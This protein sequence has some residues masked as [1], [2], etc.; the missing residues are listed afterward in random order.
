MVTLRHAIKISALRDRVFSALADTDE[1]AAWHIG[2]VDGDIAVGSTFRPNPKPGVVF[3]WRTEEIVDGERIRQ[4]C[5][6]GPGNSAGKTL[7]LT[8]SDDAD[9]TTLVT[10]TD[11]PWREDDPGLPFCNTRWAEV[12][13][14]LQKYVETEW[15]RRS[16]S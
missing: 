7:S 5:V 15:H 2:G 6:E 13:H 8:V 3:G 12:R 16:E 4:Q 11:G 1:M 9:E 14:N 10:L